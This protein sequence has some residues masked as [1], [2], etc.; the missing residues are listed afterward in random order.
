MP[1]K[2]R[3]L[4]EHTLPAG[5]L[6]PLHV[7]HQAWQHIAINF[8][9]G[10]PP[11]AG[12]IVVLVVVDRFTK[13]SHFIPLA[14]PFTTIQVAKLF[15]DHIYKLHGLPQSIVFDRDIIFLSHLWQELFCAAITDLH[16]STAYH[17]QSDTQSEHTDACLEHY[18]R[19]I[20]GH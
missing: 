8:I 1:K 10:I 5:L 6:Q 7:P 11:S 2:Q 18:L 12:K 16:H 14:H 17:P 15:L 3:R 20:I 13:Y 9:E 4:G 19:C